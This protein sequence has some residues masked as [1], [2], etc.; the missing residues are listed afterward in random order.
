V[1]S[2][3]PKGVYWADRKEVRETSSND[4]RKLTVGYMGEIFQELKNQ[5][6]EITAPQKSVQTGQSK[7][8]G[9][10]HCP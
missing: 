5:T 3:E 4:E 10:A 6:K 7:P 1:P 8:G 9:K 2:I